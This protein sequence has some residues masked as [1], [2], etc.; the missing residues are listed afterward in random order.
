M[1]EHA[2][3]VMPNLCDVYDD[4]AKALIT[5]K[6]FT[7]EE[8]E[9]TAGKDPAL[10]ACKGVVTEVHGPM[11]RRIGGKDTT[12]NE[13]L[14]VRVIDS[15]SDMGDDHKEWL[16]IKLAE[17]LIKSRAPQQG[18]IPK[19]KIVGMTNHLEYDF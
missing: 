13:C 12:F 10:N 7:L 14:R 8:V 4:E 18:P 16:N 9:A 5:S 11:A 17:T 1:Q 6:T 19:V 2:V 3:A 15:L